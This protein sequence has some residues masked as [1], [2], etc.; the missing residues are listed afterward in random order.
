[1]LSHDFANALLKRRNNDLRFVAEVVNPGEEEDGKLTSTELADDRAREVY[2]TDEDV[3]VVEYDSENDCL[4]VYLGPIFAGSEGE[5]TLS[6]EEV[7]LVT[8]ALSLAAG[9]LGG[10]FH[11]KRDA[12]L[13][14]RDRLRQGRD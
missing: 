10:I 1:M 8:E 2:G 13:K 14:L 6:A 5:A 3:E 12:T 9:G 7:D 11:P 4:N